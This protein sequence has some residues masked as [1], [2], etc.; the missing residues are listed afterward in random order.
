MLSSPLSPIL[1][2]L[3]TSPLLDITERWTH[4][5]LTL[6]VNDGAIYA[7]LA[8]TMAATAKAHEGLMQSITWLAHNGLEVDHSK[9]EL[10]IFQPNRLQ[11]NKVGSER[12]KMK[13]SREAGDIVTTV[14]SLK[15]LGIF[16]NH[17]LQWKTHVDTMT[18]CTRSTIKG[19][20]LLE[21]SVRGLDFLNWQKVYNRLVIPKLTYGAQVWY[22][23]KGQKGLIARMNTTQNEGLHKITGVF[24]TTPVEPIH[25]LTGIPPISHVL[26][27]LMHAYT[28]RLKGLNPSLGQSPYDTHT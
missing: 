3:Y 15:L 8:T 28:N 24:K 2:A 5:D 10:M 21:N 6:Y 19:I 27:K 16:I 17:C 7:T 9:T 26:P 22:T 12:V 18:N 23:G 25:N 11:P 20:N 4:K 13:F 1:L 14:P